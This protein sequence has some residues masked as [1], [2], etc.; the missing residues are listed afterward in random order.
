MGDFSEYIVYVDESGDHGLGRI[1]PSYPVFVLA[2]CIFKKSD[3]VSDVVPALQRL[4]FATFG[5]D[6][7]VL[8]ERDIRKQSGDFRILTDRSA[9]KQFLSD[10]TE[11]MKAARFTVIASVIRKERLR[12]AYSTP[13]SPY[14]LALSFCLERLFLY[15][16]DR[17]AHKSKVHVV[18]EKRG[19]KEDN[20]LE[21]HFRRVCA[22][23]NQM[24]KK[25]PLPFEP[26]FAAKSVNCSGL[27]LAD[28]VARPIGLSVLR[29][30]QSNRAY[31]VIETKLRKSNSGNVQG[32]GLKVFP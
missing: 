2:F 32:Y 1:D 19:E 6:M 31:A 20:D 22:G 25:D 21:L 14:D 30:G 24:G 4:K 28:L 15:L 18:F 3:Y 7:V 13:H 8:H 27:Q 9:E 12:N 17:S 11:L 23:H 29:P 5:H 16:R 10:L 26:I